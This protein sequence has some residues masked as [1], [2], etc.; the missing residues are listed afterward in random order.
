MKTKRPLHTRQTINGGGGGGRRG[1][2]RKKKDVR[3]RAQYRRSEKQFWDRGR[4]E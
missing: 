4:M 1:K 3:G 2:L